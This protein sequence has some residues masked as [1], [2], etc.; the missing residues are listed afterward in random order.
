MQS[1][2][3]YHGAP[4]GPISHNARDPP[5]PQQWSSVQHIVRHLYVGEKLPL[6]EVKQ[7]LERDY[8]FRNA[9]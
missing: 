5:T 8:G 9:R 7:I 6:K 3:S 1:G 2:A 4:A